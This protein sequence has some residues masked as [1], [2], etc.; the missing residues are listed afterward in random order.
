MTASG[1]SKNNLLSL[2]PVDYWAALYPGRGGFQTDDAANNLMREAYAVGVFDPDDI[3]G[4][5]AWI[6]D[7]RIVVHS[8]D[9][10]IVDGTSTPVTAIDSS[11][12]YEINRPMNLQRGPMINREQGMAFI[13]MLRGISWERP[14]NAS[15]LAGWCVIAPVCGA[16]N[17]RPHVWITGGAGTGK[18]WIMRE[19]VSE[20]MGKAALVLQGESTEAGIRQSLGHDARP[21]I[22]DE[23]EAEDKASHDR[24]EKILN[25]M[26]ASS[27]ES[28]AVMLKGS[29]GHEAR[30]FTI[31][32]CFC[33]ASIIYQARKH[34]DLTRV[35]VLGVKRNR[36][37]PLDAF[38]VLKS[39]Y[40]KVMTPEFVK[41]FHTRTLTLMPVLLK[42]IEVFNRVAAEMFGGQRLADQIAPMC[43]GAALLTS[44]VPVTESQARKWIQAQDWRDEISLDEERDEYQ[45][46]NYLMEQVIMVEQGEYGTK[47]ER[48]IGELIAT[49]CGGG[50][51]ATEVSNA[52]ERLGRLGIRCDGAT[53][54]IS[55]TASAIKH[56][57]KGTQWEKNHGKVLQRIDDAEP[58]SV[59]YFSAGQSHRGVK[60][61]W[62]G[63][64]SA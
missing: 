32:S 23:A 1:L 46:L 31:R 3:R 64:V 20:L 26:R 10:L 25:L 7:G 52:R 61:R 15:L 33:F 48:T 9:K 43:A 49:C 22:F 40:A 2:A 47:V 60:L 16:L 58:T 37:N 42:N 4:R 63:D 39:T 56:V 13:D 17:W 21:V 24:I 30:S 51:G 53:F 45:C 28:D 19:V 14:V 59:V 55:N 44:D 34:A 18:T 11:Y 6:D 5:G 27:A 12:I 36:V 35:T 29:S 50:Y 62:R 57:L 38:E 54:T 41:G 8:G